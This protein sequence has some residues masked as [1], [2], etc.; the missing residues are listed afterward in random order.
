MA[1]LN[2]GRELLEAAVRYAL[3]NAAMVTPA[4]LSGPTPCAGWDVQ[5]LIGHLTD[6]IG[7]LEGT[8]A[9]GGAGS[10]GA[11]VRAGRESGPGGRAGRSISCGAGQPGCWTAGRPPVRPSA[12]SWPAAR[13]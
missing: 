8:I 9:S 13:S 2:R 6:S 7:V 3:T 12:S 4:L 1:P 11:Q 5:T 10:A